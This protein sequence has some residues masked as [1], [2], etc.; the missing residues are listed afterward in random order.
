[1][2]NKRYFFRSYFNYYIHFT[3]LKS[4]TETLLRFTV[5]SVLL[6][7]TKHSEDMFGYIRGSYN[8]EFFCR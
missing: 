2:R 4:F 6:G 8:I 5:D 3:V 1:M 7:R